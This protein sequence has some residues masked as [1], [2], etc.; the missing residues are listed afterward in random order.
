MIE[1]LLQLS[2]S[3]A[4]RWER[5][6]GEQATEPFS[7]HAN[8]MAVRLRSRAGDGDQP[9][10]LDILNEDGIAVKTID[11]SLSATPLYLTKFSELYLLARRDAS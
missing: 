6:S 7:V 9:Y 10:V 5:S 2:R 3:G 1:C 4:I 8:E 11:P